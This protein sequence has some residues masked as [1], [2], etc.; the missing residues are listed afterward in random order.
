MYKITKCNAKIYAKKII[1]ENAS[2]ENNAVF[3]EC[4]HILKEAQKR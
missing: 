3:K 4:I 2:K 1:L